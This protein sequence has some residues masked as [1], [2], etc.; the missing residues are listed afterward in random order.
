MAKITFR[1]DDSKA[2]ARIRALDAA[3]ANMQPV[4]AT[5]GRVLVNRVRL[6]FKL[7]ID[8]WGSP[9]AKLKIRRGQPLRDTGRLQRSIV[10]RAD[11]EG[12]TVGTGLRAE[13]GASYPAVHQFGAT[14]GP[15]KAKRLVF[16]GPGGALVFAKKVTIPARPFLPL[17]RG[18]DVVAL[19][20]PWSVD[21]VR[22]LRAYF[23]RVTEKA[24]A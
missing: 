22:A 9:W 20:I 24:V 19:P 2:V 7:G 4:Y 6:C 12:V 21:V 14:I 1:L 11:A 16:P 18:S 17:R 13:S 10:A 5:V 3:T 8:P 23:A 15:A